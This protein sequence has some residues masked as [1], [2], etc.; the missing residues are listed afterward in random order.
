MLLAEPIA[1]PHHQS[2]TSECG[3]CAGHVSPVRNQEIVDG[4]GHKGPSQGDPGAGERPVGEFIPDGQVIVDAQEDLREHQ[5]RYDLQSLQVFR[6]IA[7]AH[8]MLP[9][10]QEQGNAQK[11]EAANDHEEFHHACVGALCAD[12]F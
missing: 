3:P 2:V 5:N 6:M 8:E 1:P 7:D 10:I 9:D 11:T 4:H 12:L